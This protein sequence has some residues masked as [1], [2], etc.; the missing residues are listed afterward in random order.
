MKLR[1]MG[2]PSLQF[3]LN[4]HICP[5]RGI[6]EYNPFDI[7]QVRPEKINIGIIGSGDSIDKILE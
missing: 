2:E 1:Y 6:F 7:G 4:Q 5:K 3:G